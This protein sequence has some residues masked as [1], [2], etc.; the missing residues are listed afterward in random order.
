M[1]DGVLTKFNPAES[2]GLVNLTFGTRNFFSLYNL[3]VDDHDA[4]LE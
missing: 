1:K 3:L 2:A 4:D